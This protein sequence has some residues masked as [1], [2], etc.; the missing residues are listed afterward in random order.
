MAGRI[1]LLNSL[2]ICENCQEILPISDLLYNHIRAE[3]RCLVCGEVLTG[4]S[5]GCVDGKKTQWVGPDGEWTTVKPEGI[6]RLGNNFVV[7]DME[8]IL[9]L[10]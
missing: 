8:S 1:L 6:F 3:L 5:F 9:S 4:T 2:G 10:P 7:P